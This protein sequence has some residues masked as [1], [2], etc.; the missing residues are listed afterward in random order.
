MILRNAKR[1]KFGRGYT[2]DEKLLCLSIYKRSPSAYCYLCSFLPLP[3]SRRL[4]QMLTKIKL[5]CEFMQTMRDCLKE[6]SDRMEDPQEKVCALMRDEVSLKLH[7]KY[8]AEKDKVVGLEDWGTNR[9]SKYADNALVFMLRGINSEWKIPITYNFC[10]GQTTHGQLACCVK[11]VVQEVTNAGF[12]VAC[13]V[14]DQG[15]SNMRAIKSMQADTDLIR[16][17]KGIEK[18]NHLLYYI[19]HYS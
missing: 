8:C 2:S 12:V 4:R 5:N 16:E 3:S 9:T 14:C 15:S 13:T 10:A 18:C 11:E 17:E 19:F 6:M 1:H 7:L